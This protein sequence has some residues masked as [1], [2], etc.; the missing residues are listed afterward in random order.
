MFDD[1]PVVRTELKP[2]LRL[3][4]PRLG[5]RLRDVK[6]ALESGDYEE[7]PDGGVRAAGEELG[8]EEVLRGEGAAVEG[9]AI[10]QHG[11]LSVALDLELDDELRRKGRVRELIHTVNAMRRDAGLE[12]S[13]RIVLTLGPEEADLAAHAEWIKDET[14][15]IDIGTGDALAIKKA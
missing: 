5:P 7:L 15:A 9:F 6:A 8:A 4:G 11:E 12:L 14:L 2:N 1:G 3:L 10:A 13:D